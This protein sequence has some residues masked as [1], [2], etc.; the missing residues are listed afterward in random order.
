M[1]FSLP[2]PDGCKDSGITCPIKAG[3]KYTYM[4]HLPILS[5]YPRV[6]Q[7]EVTTLNFFN[8]ISYYPTFNIALYQIRLVQ[9][10]FY[11]SKID[12]MSY[13]KYRKS[14]P[15]CFDIFFISPL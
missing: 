9:F 2:N 12:R 3:Q 13:V 7:L 11:S 6:S 4:S 8:I 1:P 15:K 5:S 10:V 14:F